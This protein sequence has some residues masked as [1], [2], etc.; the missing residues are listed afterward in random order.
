M[1]VSEKVQGVARSVITDST[2]GQK[3]AL[4]SLSTWMAKYDGE[5]RSLTLVDIL[6]GVASYPQGSDKEK[7]DFFEDWLERICTERRTEL[8]ALLPRMGQCCTNP[9]LRLLIETQYHPYREAAAVKLA[10]FMWR[11]RPLPIME[12]ELPP[13]PI[14]S[15]EDDEEI[16]VRADHID[17]SLRTLNMGHLSSHEVVIRQTNGA[18]VGASVPTIMSMGGFDSFASGTTTP[19]DDESPVHRARTPESGGSDDRV[20]VIREDIVLREGHANHVPTAVQEAILSLVNLRFTGSQITR[21]THEFPVEFTMPNHVQLDIISGNPLLQAIEMSLTNLRSRTTAVQVRNNVLPTLLSQLWTLQRDLSSETT[22][23]LDAHAMRYFKSLY[24]MCLISKVLSK[25]TP[26]WFVALTSGFF[27]N[28]TP[29]AR[30]RFIE[31]EKTFLS[32]SAGLCPRFSTKAVNGFKGDLDDADKRTFFFD[33]IAMLD[34]CVHA[35][36]NLGLLGA[37]D[38]LKALHK[39]LNPYPPPQYSKHH[40]NPLGGPDPSIYGTIDGRG[41]RK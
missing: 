29:E 35:A 3:K 23:I 21:I 33:F 37:S 1:Q 15:V 9:A 28:E 38:K 14:L 40:P 34:T 10:N 6:Q 36:E 22:T 31:I 30:Q 4:V 32:V 12:V 19:P 13:L 11:H 27:S 39:A 8:S 5:V 20:L 24:Y 17:L 18:S 16:V 2:Q 7:I 41:D 25:A 26:G